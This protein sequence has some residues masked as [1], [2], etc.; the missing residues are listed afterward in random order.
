MLP[1]DRS[2]TC[3]GKCLSLGPGSSLPFGT[4]SLEL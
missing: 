2:S 3:A 1:P 4:A